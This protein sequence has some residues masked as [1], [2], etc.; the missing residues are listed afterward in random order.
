MK[1]LMRFRLSCQ[2]SRTRWLRLSATA[3]T[4]SVRL[5]A[6]TH[7]QQRARDRQLAAGAWAH[8]ELRAR[9]VFRLDDRCHVAENRGVEA[10]ADHLAGD[11]EHILE[12]RLCGRPV[13][14]RQRAHG[15]HR[16]MVRQ[17]KHGRPGYL[18]IC[19]LQI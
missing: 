19:G 6:P 1:W 5:P 16:P 17:R 3:A 4:P 14:I 7:T 15:G 9:S 18:L 12:R 10:R 2:E 11:T 13:A 8:L